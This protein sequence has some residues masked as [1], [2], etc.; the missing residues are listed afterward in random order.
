MTSENSP[1]NAASGRSARPTPVRSRSLPSLTRAETK[2]FVRLQTEW[3]AL[4]IS[5]KDWAIHKVPGAAG[6]GDDTD[7]WLATG[8]VEVDSVEART[9]K[10][11][12]RFSGNSVIDFGC[13]PGRMSQ[14]L[15]T[16]FQSVTGVDVS[17]EVV[18]LARRVNRFGNRCRF[19]NNQ[20]PDLN[21]FDDGTFDAAF[22]VY[23]F[24]HMP[25]WLSKRYISE[26][27]RVVKPGGTIAFQL[28]GGVAWKLL[29]RLPESWLSYI[30]NYLVRR[31]TA[32][33]GQLR[34][35]DVHWIKP[36]AVTT[37]LK[38]CGVKVHSVDR[39][40]EPDGRMIGYWYFAT[41]IEPSIRPTFQRGR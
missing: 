18:E 36:A 9:R 26:L 27:I 7:R 5:A 17:S 24:Q 16:H 38:Q 32:H 40:P 28:H 4:G 35:W 25:P 11:G 30:H 8:R 23:V 13:G 10:L 29:D 37:F 12:V 31:P 21:L 41:R 6:P 19:V 1:L 3:N 14:A 39:I 20:S 34:S 15:T 22:S 33:L 2:D